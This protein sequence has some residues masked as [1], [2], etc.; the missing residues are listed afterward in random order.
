SLSISAGVRYSRVRS[1]ALGRLTGTVRFSLLGATTL[2]CGFTGVSPAFAIATYRAFFFGQSVKDAAPR[3]P[4]LRHGRVEK[5]VEWSVFYRPQNCRFGSES[6]LLDSR[7][8]I[9]ERFH[10]D[11]LA[12][13]WTGAVTFGKNATAS[14]GI[15]ERMVGSTV[16]KSPS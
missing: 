14:V 12:L 15:S 3:P 5:A 11:R 7:E 16:R 4:I 13:V 6:V 2:K 9:R 1:S 10:Q 8:T